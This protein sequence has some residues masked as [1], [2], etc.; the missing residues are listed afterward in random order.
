MRLTS[1][2]RGWLD[3]VAGWEASCHCCGWIAHQQVSTTKV[4]LPV[5]ACWLFWV[6]GARPRL[7]ILSSGVPAEVSQTGMTLLQVARLPAM[8][9]WH[10]HSACE[11]FAHYVHRELAS[12][13]ILTWGLAACSRSG[14]ESALGILVV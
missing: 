1:C 5:G 6:R 9:A 10:G 14:M 3:I 8:A 12:I 7:H 4:F 11:G 13:S 2:S